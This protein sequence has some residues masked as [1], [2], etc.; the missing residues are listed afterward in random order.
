MGPLARKYGGFARPP[1][2]TL[3][4]LGKFKADKRYGV[5]FG[6]RNKVAVQS[7][8]ISSGTHAC[9]GSALIFNG[10]GW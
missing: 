4:G 9:A 2:G 7:G 3:F 8:Y 10:T 6:T 5:M 1:L